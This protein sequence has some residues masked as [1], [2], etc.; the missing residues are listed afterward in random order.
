MTN[1][2]IAQITYSYYPLKG[3]ADIYLNN[4]FQLLR[5]KGYDQ[6][7]FQKWERETP[8]YVRCLPPLPRLKGHDFWFYPLFLLFLA[9][10]LADYDLLVVHYPPYFLPLCWHKRTITISHGVT[11]DDAPNSKTGRFKKALAKFAFR[12]T[13]SF[14]ANDTFFLREMGLNIRPGEKKFTQIV[15]KRWFIPNCVDI[16]LFSKSED[17]QKDDIIVPRNLYFSRGLHLA[18]EAY[19]MIKETFKSVNMVIVGGSGQVEYSRYL[20]KRVDE[21]GLKG[22]VKFIGHIPWKDMKRIYQRAGLCLIPSLYGEGTSLS[23][24]EAMASG[25]ATISTNVGGLSDLPTLK[26]EQSA[27]SLAEEILRVYPKRKE[28]GEW[29]RELVR[30]EFS[31]DLWRQAWLKVIESTLT[32]P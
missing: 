18:I 25:I 24:L 30:N 17:N 4:L 31:M 20:L 3:G 1:L 22:R 6:V 32:I 21:L 12:K 5:E 11:W 16:N 27:E 23:A 9:P 15:E 28:I 2:K 7:V 8:E 26:C 29:Q 19:A 10:H 14:V 13:T